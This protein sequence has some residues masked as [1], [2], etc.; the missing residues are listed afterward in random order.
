MTD[1]FQLSTLLRDFGRYGAGAGVVEED[2]EGRL[3]NP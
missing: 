3:L 1:T 2:G